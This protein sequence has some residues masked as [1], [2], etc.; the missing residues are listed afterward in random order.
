MSQLDIGELETAGEL[1]DRLAQGG[2]PLMLQVLDDLA[3]GRATETPQDGSQATKAPK[4][5]REAS[6]I[7]W[8]QPADTIARQIRGMYPW[9]GCRVALL[10]ESANRLDRLTLVRA[11]P[12]APAPAASAGSITETGSIAAAHGTVEI[13]ELHP[14]GKR[15]MPLASYQNGHPWR[16]GLR[17]EPLT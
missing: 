12:A 8:T 15:P 5:S 3:T 14:E 6:R 13:V 1:H 7:N 10:D 9:P 16:P 4:L 2:A 17:L 11:R